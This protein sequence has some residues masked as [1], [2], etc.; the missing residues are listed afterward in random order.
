MD[1][2]DVRTLKALAKQKA[3]VAKIA[4]IV[5]T[6]TRRNGSQGAYHR[7]VVK[8]SIVVSGTQC[9]G[10]DTLTRP[11]H[12][13]GWAAWLASDVSGIQNV[14]DYWHSLCWGLPS[15]LLIPVNFIVIFNSA[16]GDE[17]RS[18]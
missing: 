1:E 15:L 9:N 4:G 18:D 16:C 8:H 13:Y 17:A 7:C 11:V 14:S 2:D 5:E 3:G 12:S 6:N 10:L